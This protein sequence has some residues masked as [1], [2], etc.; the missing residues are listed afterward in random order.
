VRTIIKW[1]AGFTL[2]EMMIV[3]VLVS[4]LALMATVTLG[5][6]S[7]RAYAVAMQSDLRNIA[8]AQEAYIEQ[9]LAETGQARYANRMRDLD[10]NLSAG[11]VIRLRGNQ[12]GWSAR[13]THQRVAGKR[14]SIVQ[15]DMR[16]FPPA[17]RSDQGKIVCD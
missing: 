13:A 6:S 1:D 3:L 5:S 14:C 7:D 2:V 12:T 4:V 11:V 15:G 8:A 16:P 9:R 17:T 10:V